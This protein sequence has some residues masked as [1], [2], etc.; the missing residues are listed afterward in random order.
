MAKQ[1][2]MSA[3]DGA[4]K[5]ANELSGGCR[6]C[7]AGARLPPKRRPL[8]GRAVF[9]VE[10]LI[11]KAAGRLWNRAKLSAHHLVSHDLDEAL[12]SAPMPHGGGPKRHTRAERSAQSANAYVRDSWPT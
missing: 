4:E 7:R 5:N 12:K 3:E 8:D 6:A 2:E 9:G 11:P 1:I 10:P